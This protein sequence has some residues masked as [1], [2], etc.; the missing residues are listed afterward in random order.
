MQKTNPSLLWTKFHK[1]RNKVTQLIRESKSSF[2]NN[3]ADKRKL[4]PHTSRDLWP[5]LKC[6]ISPKSSCCI[7]PLEHNGIIQIDEDYEKAQP[8]NN[9]Y[10]NQTYLDEGNAILP[11]VSS[12]VY[13]LY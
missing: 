2:Y 6:F 4:V 5:I 8:L 1:L 12:Y 3:I 7:P 10:T 11:D 9:F 13:I